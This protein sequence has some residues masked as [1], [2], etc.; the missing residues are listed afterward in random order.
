MLESNVLITN[1]LQ[2]IETSN[3]SLIQNLA[4]DI[5]NWIL[6]IRLAR[7]RCPPNYASTDIN[8][9]QVFC[10]SVIEEHL[11]PL[12]NKCIILNNRSM[13]HKCVKLIINTSHGAQNMVDQK[14][15]MGFENAL[16]SAILASVPSILKTSHA[17]SLRWFTMLITATSNYDSQGPISVAIM[18]LLLDVLVEM[19]KRSSSLNSIL[20]S[21]FGLYGMPFESELFDAEVPSFGKG[22]NLSYCN[23]FLPKTNS[24][25]VNNGAQQQQQQQQNQFSDLKSFCSGGK[26]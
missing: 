12:I 22:T 10:V 13:A 7:L 5:L 8:T 26:K 16:K 4:I 25:G 11:R 14:Q 9:Q 2:K 15:C 18:R 6:T 1:L 19:S 3:N 24:V 23:I 21:R 17:G 20:Q